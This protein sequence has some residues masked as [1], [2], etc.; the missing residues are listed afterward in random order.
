[1]PVTI[2]VNS[3][4]SAKVHTSPL[5]SEQLEKKKM[6]ILTNFTNTTEREMAKYNRILEKEDTDISKNPEKLTIK[7]LLLLDAFNSIIVVVI[8]RLMIRS[9]MH[10]Q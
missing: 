1:M 3:K 4:S 8:T 10:R 7:E 5:L 9:L 2:K 6:A